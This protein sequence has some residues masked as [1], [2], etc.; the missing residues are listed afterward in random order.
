MNDTTWCLLFSLRALRAT[1]KAH[2]ARL[3]L[4]NANDFPACR[5]PKLHLWQ[6]FNLQIK[7]DFLIKIN[8]HAKYFFQYRIFLQ[9]LI[10]TTNP[11]PRPPLS[12]A[13]F[14]Q[15]LKQM[16]YTYFYCVSAARQM[17]YFFILRLIYV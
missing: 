3:P 10:T 8:S 7:K 4:H 11:T 12:L 15:T 6:A 1:K 16:T 2:E 5:A 17:Y 9:K 14:E 13:D